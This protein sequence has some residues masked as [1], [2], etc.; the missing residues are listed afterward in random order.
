VKD[1]LLYDTTLRDGAQTEGIAF[2]A[3]DK[4]KLARKLEELGLDYIEG[5][6]SAPSNR[7]DMEF[8]AHMR[9]HPLSR[10]KLVVFGMTCRAGA[11]PQDDPGVRNLV[12]LG[13]PVAALVG[14]S[15]DLH[16]ADVLRISP[17]ENLR[18]IQDSVAYVKANG[19]EAGFDAEHFFDGL[20]HNR[21]YALDCLKAAE[22]AGAD[23]ICLCDTN[24]GVLPEEAR[25]A[26]E[27]VCATVRVPVGVH[28]HDDCG[29]AIA[30]SLTSVQ[31]GARQVQG[32]ING[33]AERCGMANLCTLIPNL[34]VKLG[35]AC[36]TE[37]Q[38]SSLYEI[39]HYVAS[40]ANMPPPERDA[41]VGRSAF[42]HKGGMHVDG[43]LKNQRS[44][45]HIRPEVVGN[46]RRHLISDQ[47]GRNAVV[48]KVQ[49]LDLNLDKASPVAQELMA[50][51]KEMEHAGYQFE[52]AEASFELMVR[53]SV[54][55]YEPRFELEGFRVLIEKDAN[56]AIRTEATIKVRVD[57]VSE[58]TAAE[59]DGP[60]HALDSALRKALERFYPALAGIKLTDFKVRVVNGPD[61]GTAASVRV[62]V[63]SRAGARTWTT[64][65]VHTN[66]IEASWQ[67][68][69]DGV[70][71]GL[72]QLA[73][74][75]T[76][77]PPRA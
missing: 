20:K 55:M 73:N 41:Y 23:W 52:G 68:L 74:G 54:G 53:K 4:V 35:R 75:T 36:V 28:F 62:M 19:V 25:A 39:A 37:E 69:V 9:E 29:L 14:K 15:W 12:E 63:E 58:H 59:G 56:R 31:A 22:A 47:A 51:L 1:L 40:V 57:G 13:A 26:V 48:H 33:Y 64:V 72:L 8:F 61:E 3:D 67:A 70:E 49:A 7:T 77:D 16:V 10:A 32:T 60:V 66:I 71:Y 18:I 2:S 46:E 24:G 11:A 30:N 21:E 50:R 27:A 42:A 65:G 38:L 5:G 45:E 43:M 17:E 34:Q 44:Y 6:F 76:E